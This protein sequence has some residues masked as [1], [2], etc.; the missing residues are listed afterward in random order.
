MSK[1]SCV[2]GQ[3]QLAEAVFKYENLYNIF[4]DTQM[5]GLWNEEAQM[6]VEETTCWKKKK[7]KFPSW[8]IGKG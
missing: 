4:K 1:N 8:Q 2:I 5:V 3:K 7:K 6:C